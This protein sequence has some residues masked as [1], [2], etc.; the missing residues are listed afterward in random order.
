VSDAVSQL[1]YQIMGQPQ[2]PA[3]LVPP[4]TQVGWG[5]EAGYSF[6][7]V[8]GQGAESPLTTRLPVFLVK[9]AL[10]TVAS[11]PA[12]VETMTAFEAELLAALKQWYVNFHPSETNASLLFEVTLFASGSQQTLA[13][14]L[15]IE[16]PI[17]ANNPGWWT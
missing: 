17:P 16:V 4:D 11:P 1:I 5:L 8:P 15:D 9:T 3:K 13:K 14:L 7:L 12:G 2:P 10:T 6:V